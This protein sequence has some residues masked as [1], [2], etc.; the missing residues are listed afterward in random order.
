MSVQTQIDRLNA[1]K[2][3]IRTN[4]VAQ[5][6][7][8]PEDTM[9]EAMAEQ[10]LSVAG[11]DGQRG[12]GLLPV[13]TAPSGYT[14]AAGGITPKYRMEISTIKTQAGVTEVLLGDTVRYSYYHYPIAYLDSSYAYF[15]TRVSIRGATGAE[16]AAG[17]DGNDYVLTEADKSEIA[18]LVIEM[19]GGNPV[20]GYVDENN[21]IVVSGELADGT[22][23]VK[24]EMDNGNTVNIGNLV[25]DSNVYYSVTNNLTNCTNSNSA[26]KAVQ[27]GSYS[28]TITA[29]SGYELKSV[30]ATMGGSPVTVSGGTINIANV[31]GN[32]VITAVAEEV[33]EP[34]NFAGTITVGRLSGSS[35]AVSTDSPSSR[36]TDFVAVQKGDIVVAYGAN[37]A[38]TSKNNTVGAYNSSKAKVSVKNYDEGGTDNY[39][40]DETTSTS[41]T[42]TITTDA[43]KYIRIGLI[44]T[45]TNDDIKVNIKRNGSWL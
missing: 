45:G 1:V 11:E 30:S 8:V 34:T 17:A 26:T 38:D 28:A 21:N 18:A 15:T 44:P 32:I 43:V 29:K 14:T 40:V 35:G 12:T 24:Y 37:F 2:E 20:F 5:G 3:R 23:S 42:I 36:V 25:L 16:G 22:Y 13:T 9:L 10:I 7:T 4:L 19:L 27:G 41:G 6:I 39:T 33:V 31:T